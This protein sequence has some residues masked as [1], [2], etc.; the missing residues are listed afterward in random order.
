MDKYGLGYAPSRQD[1]EMQRLQEERLQDQQNSKMNSRVIRMSEFNEDDVDAEDD[2]D[3]EHMT[4][5]YSK[6][7]KSD[8]KFENKFL[9]LKNEQVQ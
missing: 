6:D 7:S 2:A 4:Q 9:N 8:Y 5:I 1:L 3:G